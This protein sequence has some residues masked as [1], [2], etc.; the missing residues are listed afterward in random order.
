AK[1]FFITVS[2]A[3]LISELSSKPNTI[4]G[5]R[6]FINVIEFPFAP[7]SN[8]SNTCFIRNVRHNTHRREQFYIHSRDQLNI[9]PVRVVQYTLSSVS[10]RIWSRGDPAE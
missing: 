6:R 5:L 10:H 4:S 8:S 7:M 9:G 2:T 1:F 3:F